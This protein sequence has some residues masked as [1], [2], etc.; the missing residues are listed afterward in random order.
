[1]SV[2][3]RMVLAAVLLATG[4]LAGCTPDAPSSLPPGVAKDNGAEAVQGN[5]PAETMHVTIYFATQDAKSLV[6]EVRAIAKTVHPAQKAVE[7]LLGE[8]KNPQLTRVLPEGTK[9][10][11]ITIKDHIAYVDF[12]DK[13]IKNSGGGSTQEILMVA[14]VVD[15]LTEFPEISQ[16]Q[17]MVEGKKVETLTGHMDV[18]EPLSRSEQ[19]IKKSL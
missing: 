4:L 13:L 10:R 7:L 6:G 16:V 1:M 17:F 15:T 2:R 3:M 18:G 5:N 14:A 12:N 11:G 8:P 19:I 9:L